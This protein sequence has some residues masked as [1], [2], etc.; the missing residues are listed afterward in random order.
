M[1]GLRDA[2]ASHPPTGP[3]LASW[4]IPGRTD[5][6]G[7]RL[8]MFDNTD[9]PSLELLRFR[10][11]LAATP[12]FEDVLRDRVRRLHGFRHPS[13]S[14]IRALEHLD[15]GEGLALVSVHAGGQRLSELFDKRPRRGLDPAVVGWLL[16]ELTPALAALQSHGADVSHGAL[17]ADRIALTPEGRLCITE[18]VL[19]STLQNLELDPAV[20]WR[21]F[22][23]LATGDGSGRARFDARTD[24]VQ[25]AGVALSMLVGRPLTPQDLQHRLPALLDEVSELATPSSSHHV[26]PL[27]SWLERAL[28]LQ[29][30]AYG[31]AAE[32]EAD[33]SELPA[34]D[35]SAMLVAPA[36]FEPA[37]PEADRL[38][39]PAGAQETP[40]APPLRRPV[41][42]RQAPR[43]ARAYPSVADFVDNFPSESIIQTA[44]PAPRRTAPA[45]RADARGGPAG[46]RQDARPREPIERANGAAPARAPV[47]VSR[48]AEIAPP[49]APPDV[50]RGGGTASRR[51][52]RT[53]SARVAAAV[54]ALAVVEA[55]VIAGLLFRGVPPAATALTIESPQSGDTVLVNGEEVG[56]TPFELAI[57]S[58]TQ[59]VRVVSAAAVPASAAPSRSDRVAATAPESA[60]TRAAAPAP[61]AVTAPRQGGVRL[62]AP[63]DVMVLQGDRLLGSTSDGPIFL[64]AGTHQVQLVNNALGV[65]L[66]QTVTIRQGQI[67]TQ[68]VDLP[69]GRV[70]LNAQPW[71]QVFIDGNAVGETPLANVS[72]PLGEH[73][74][75]FRHP[76][77]GE[78]RE[79]VLVRADAVA[80]VSAAFDR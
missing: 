18:H 50:S 30:P 28:R 67:G 24:V 44:P 21:N 64:P 45:H 40:A 47:F 46:P 29:A 2:H 6:F 12:G 77:H 16:R 71:A 5:G 55:L 65:R 26:A 52:P 60:T 4:Y 36:A 1:N 43:P 8:V 51:R 63:V 17:T 27:R 74:I 14:P 70:N 39:A 7:D 58:D 35:R 76:E 10:P 48:P 73:E 62:V 19:G 15:E 38:P 72:V 33:V 49:W 22:G 78:R 9:T 13:F 59:S 3:G 11:D 41:P 66:L 37:S 20:L 57:G 34:H 61:S 68:T 53:V 25:L 75:L 56:V 80:R 42:P 69:Q 31:S 23:L 79:R 32:A 54:A